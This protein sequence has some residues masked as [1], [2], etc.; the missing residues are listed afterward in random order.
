MPISRLSDALAKRLETLGQENRLKGDESVIC[1]VIPA[2]DGGGPRYLLEGEGDRPFLRMN[3]NSY[4]GMS[5][6]PG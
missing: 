2:R 3:S 4:L 5:F 6:R 1:G